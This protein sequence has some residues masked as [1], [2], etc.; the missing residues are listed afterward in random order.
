MSVPLWS[1]FPGSPGYV[2]I[3][4]LS[5][6]CPSTAL[7]HKDGFGFR[8]LRFRH[9]FLLWCLWRSKGRGLRHFITAVSFSVCRIRRK[10]PI[11]RFPLSN[12]DQYGEEIISSQ[13]AC[14]NGFLALLYL[15]HTPAA[16]AVKTH[17]PPWDRKGWSLSRILQRFINI[18][19][20][21]LCFRLSAQA[22]AYGGINDTL[23]SV[24]VWRML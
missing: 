23:G 8:L 16:F 24:T 9:R 19:A 10:R 22:C 14:G 5:P 20:F 21:C 13:M 11:F 2:L 7:R 3:L 15:M 4:I 6:P 1:P 17:V 18:Y 12:A